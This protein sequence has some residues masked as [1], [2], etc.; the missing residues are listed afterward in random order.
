[1]S[2]GHMAGSKAARLSAVKTL[3]HSEGM[4]S[5]QIGARSDCLQQFVSSCKLVVTRSTKMSG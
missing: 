4:L 1:M 5:E 3:Y 2:S